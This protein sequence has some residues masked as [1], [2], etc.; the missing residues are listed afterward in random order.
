MT[1]WWLPAVD[2]QTSLV[3]ALMILAFA[4]IGWML[5]GTVTPGPAPTPEHGRHRAGRPP[6]AAVPAPEPDGPLPFVPGP[7]YRDID[8]WWADL[9]TGQLP[10]LTDVDLADYYD[11]VALAGIR[12]AARARA[13]TSP[14]AAAAD[15]WPPIFAALATEMGYDPVRGFD[16]LAAAA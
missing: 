13:H 10:A 16:G 2:A 1:A 3:S 15:A 6:L 8:D 12:F 11:D 14:S 7:D 5:A 4:G 9:P